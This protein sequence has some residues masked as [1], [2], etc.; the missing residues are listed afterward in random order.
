MKILIT[1][2]QG[3]LAVEFQRQ[4]QMTDGYEVSALSREKVD[5]SDLDKVEEAITSYG[6]DIVLNCAA[7]NQV[8]KIE[9]DFDRAHKV[10]AE[11]I[12]NLA[13]CCKKE[14]ALLI[15]YS[16]DYVFDGTKE[17]FYTEDDIPKPINNYGKSKLFGEKFLLEVTDKFLLFSVSWVFGCGRQN[18]LY[19]L[20]ELAK[21]N[22]VL[23]IVADQ[24]SVPTYTEDIVKYTL[25]AIENGIR[26]IYHMTN[27]GYASRY[28]VARY[29]IEKVGL[30]NMVLPVCSDFFTA[31]AK[32][33]YFSAMSNVKLSK[34][35]EQKIPD[36]QDAIDR[37]AM[38]GWK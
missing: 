2:A 33:P 12:K 37:F 21:R 11:G 3:Q 6:P 35:L 28:E 32:R 24:V 31:P 36:W 23:R 26:G 10:N 8:D 34:T 15:H 18:F 14:D 16:T 17:S 9:E 22:H 25:L 20:L 1:G 38:R 7:Y 29:Y 30:P 5:I 4:L 27:S 13:I 19:K